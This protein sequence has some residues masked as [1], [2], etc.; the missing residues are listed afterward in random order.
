MVVL[1]LTLQL[2]V[3]LVDDEKIIEDYL[4]IIKSL[5]S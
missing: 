4:D 5:R 1:E 3:T 2:Q